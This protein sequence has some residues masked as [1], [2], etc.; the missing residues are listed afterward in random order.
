MMKGMSPMTATA[1]D[2][3]GPSDSL[4]S[5]LDHACLTAD[6]YIATGDTRP[7]R[8][9][10]INGEVIVNNPTVRHQN[11]VVFIQL[12]LGLWIRNGPGRGQTSAQLDMKVDDQNVLAPDAFWAS[13]GRIPKDGTHLD[14]IP[15]LVVEVRSPSTW[16]YDTTVK[17]RKYEVAGA[18][19]VWLVDTASN[20][21]MVYRRSTT[22]QAEF[23]VAMELGA[24]EI[25]TT[26]LL[27]DFGMD[28][29]ELFN[30]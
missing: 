16:K 30:R 13:E 14:F 24:G 18:A 4:R 25:L 2:D 12:E 20:T 15:E 11:I 17:F 6:E 27:P 28:I 8:T 19:E 23:D 22:A 21:V 26:P 10:L 1:P 29:T 5:P 7:R 3:A 9:E